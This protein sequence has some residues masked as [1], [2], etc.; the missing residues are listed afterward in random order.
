MFN[1]VISANTSTDLLFVD[2][3]SHPIAIRKEYPFC[4]KIDKDNSR[5]I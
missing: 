2:K 4:H 5:P 3:S 1:F